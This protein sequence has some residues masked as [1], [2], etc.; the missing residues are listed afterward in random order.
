MQRQWAV[1]GGR[2]APFLS[3]LERE[4]RAKL[5]RKKK[6]GGL[7]LKMCIVVFFFERWRRGVE[8][9]G[10]LPEARIRDTGPKMGPRLSQRYTV[11]TT[12]VELTT[13]EDLLSREPPSI[14]DG[15]SPESFGGA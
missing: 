11:H 10:A 13:P 5:K 7:N 8:R 6:K 4:G 15:P 9:R 14:A 3:R 2:T 12:P 1:S